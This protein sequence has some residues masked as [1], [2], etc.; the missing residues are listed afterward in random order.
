MSRFVV[1]HASDVHLDVPFEAIGRTPPHV[2]A[3]LRDASLAAWDALIDLAIARGAGAVL[4][5]GGLCGGLEHGVRAQA[6]LRDGV[7]R[8]AA[9]DIRVFIALGDRD[10]L[11]GF[12][13]IPAWPQRVTVF[14]RGEPQS[15]ALDRAGV[16]LATV[17]GVSAGGVSGSVTP[18]F[19]RPSLPGPHFGLL[20]GVLDGEAAAG[21]CSPYR[22]ADLRA[23]GLDYWALGHAH[24]VEYRSRE[25]PWIVYPGTTQGRGLA[26]AECGPKGAVLVEVVDGAVVRVDFEPLDRVRCLRV[27]LAGAADPATLARLLTARAEELRERHGGRALVLD[28]QVD[29]TPPVRRTLRQPA[30]RAELLRMLRRTAEAREPFIW[31]AAVRGSAPAARERAAALTVEDLSSGVERRRAELAADPKQRAR[32]LAQRCERLRDV[33]TAEIEAREADELLDEAA[34]VAVDALREDAP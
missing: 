25:A 33:W 23:A 9:A 26:A 19:S 5:A 7:A 12:A 16:R 2:A 29:G 34:G 28:A 31:W 27:E 13:A 4:L 6:R 30:A 18:R 24:A 17:H 11:D 1:L 15:V 22:S 21:G 3:I 14:A 32:F 8:L 10:P 20:H